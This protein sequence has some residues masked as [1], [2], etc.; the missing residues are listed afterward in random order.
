MKNAVK[1][2][3]FILYTT[4]IFFIPNNKIIF[5][6]AIINMVIIFISKVNIGKIY[7]STLR[8]FP[9]I[10][11]TFVINCILDNFYN[12]I[13]IGLK[14]LIV[15]NITI[16]YSN[17]TTIIRNSRNNKTIMQTIKDFKY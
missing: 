9:F 10:L 6:L 8:I 1:F 4:S 17:T 12:A 16:I 13:W 11:F 3:I 15:C 5:I 7:T 2:L 14:L